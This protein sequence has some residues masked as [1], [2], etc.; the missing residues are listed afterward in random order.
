MQPEQVTFP[1]GPVYK[2]LGVTFKQAR[3]VSIHPEGGPNSLA[4][5][6]MIEYTDEQ[7]KGVVE[8]VMYDYLL[9]ATGP[10]LNFGVTPGLGPEFNSHS[11]CTYGHAVDASRALD[12][13]I[14][15]M[16]KGERQTLLI[17]TGHGSC[18]CQGAAFEYIFNVDYKLRKMKLRDQADIV[19]LSNEYELGDFGV[20][21]MHLRRGGYVTHSKV[22]TESLYSE[23]GIKWITR[24]HTKEV[25]PHEVCYETIDGEEKTIRSD[26]AMLL[27]PFT[28]VGIQAFAR[29]GDEITAK[30]FAPSGFML[31]DGD[32]TKKNYDEWLPSDWPKLYQNPTYQNIFAAGIAFAP[33]HPIS[34][35]MLSRKGTPITPAPPRTGMPTGVMAREIAFNIVDMMTGK[36]DHPTRRASMANMGAACI[37]SAGAH[38]KSGTAASLTMYPIIPDY[39]KYPDTGRDMSYTTGEIGL[40]GH[41]IKHLLHHAF[42][43]KAKANPF[44]KIVPE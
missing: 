34:K 21:G 43:Y 28:G 40:A 23:R 39:E 15:R 38:I 17:G 22:F 10:K 4:P 1:L 13:L 32:Y 2:K 42:I 37:A 25:G 3:A 36:A 16:Q 29:N 6:V 18:T 31:V 7:N 19:W 8:K 35:P 24:A 30:L 33:P 44:W 5:F 41:W 20:G 26:F 14:A 9:N 11:V 12:E 27:P